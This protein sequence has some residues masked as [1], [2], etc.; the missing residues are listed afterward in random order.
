[1][2]EKLEQLVGGATRILITSHIS[3]DPDAVSSVLLFMSALELNFLDKKILACLEEMPTGLEFID[4]YQKL[5]FGPLIDELN[6]FKPDLFILLDGNN[7]ER[8]S[9]KDGQKVRDFVKADDVKTVII[10][11]HEE[12]GKDSVDVFINSFSPS[13]VQ[14]VY[15]VCFDQMRLKEPPSAAQ[16]AM[17]GFYADT[18]GFVYVKA[19]QPDKVFSFAEKLVRHGA[20]IEQTKY[21][22]ESYTEADMK[23][24]GELARNISYH[25]NYNYSY[26]TD[27]FIANWLTQGKGHSEFQRG[28]NSFLNNYIRNID[29]RSWGFIVY[30][31]TLESDGIYS[32]SFRSQNGRP[33]VSLIA[34]RLGGGGHKPAAGARFEA[35][36]VD[37]AVKTVKQTIAELAD[38]V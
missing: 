11:H 17:T 34:G 15:E 25:Q 29:D 30:K 35:K 20:D 36:S 37:E 3:P 27:D 10:D 12:A 33:D 19:G 13:T 24:I 28:T 2:Q 8:A 14:D 5:S 1:M 23:V 38:E 21:H 16:T 32:A 9:R 18:G 6:N 7:Y 4:G 22:L 31:N 26:I